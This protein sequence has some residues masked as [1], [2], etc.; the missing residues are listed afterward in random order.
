MSGNQA[1]QV[2]AGIRWSE[3]R[4]GCVG[5][6]GARGDIPEQRYVAVVFSADPAKASG[7]PLGVS[8]A[9]GLAHTG[10]WG[11]SQ[12]YAPEKPPLAAAAAAGQT[13]PP[14]VAPGGGPHS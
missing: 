9:G 2:A 14:P 13:E 5:L 8:A 1:S 11:T 12:L 10:P 4:A 6:G 3:A 7:T